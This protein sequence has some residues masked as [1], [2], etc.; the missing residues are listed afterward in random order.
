M[1]KEVAA[2][3][4]AEIAAAGKRKAAQYAFYAMAVFLALA[5]FAFALDGLHTVLAANYGAVT[6]SLS[7][8]GGLLVLALCVF[9]IGKLIKRRRGAI[10]VI[11]AS[12]IVAAPVAARLI[13]P[14]AAKRIGVL[15]SL[16]L[17]ALLGRQMG[18]H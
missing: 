8:S 6:A 3:A 17:G 1:L 18:S 11:A 4:G 12:A 9:A 2:L 5:A 13:A 10:D 16:A 15:G 14:Q 7:L